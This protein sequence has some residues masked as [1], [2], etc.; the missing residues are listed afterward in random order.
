MALQPLSS[1]TT[2]V[3]R[4]VGAAGLFAAGSLHASWAAGSSFPL[5][6]RPSLARA[7]TG[8]SRMPHPAASAA[9][10]AG[11]LGT[12]IVVAGAFG[13]GQTP[14]LVRISTG[15]SLLG[16]GLLGG[17]VATKV[18]RMP[19]PQEPFRRLDALVYRPLCI[20]WGAAVL[21]SAR[22]RS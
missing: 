2:R 7:V 6:D 8:S 9:L 12:G 15:A 4:A 17:V 21:A 19:T 14:T 20:V 3:L 10:A 5:K 13:E 11:L 16:R 1:S 18:L 22:T